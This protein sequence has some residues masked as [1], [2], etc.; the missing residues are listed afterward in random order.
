MKTRMV[1]LLTTTV[2]VGALACFGWDLALAKGGSGGGGS[3]GGGGGAAEKAAL[4]TSPALAAV[5]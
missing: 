1:K 3:H 5:T 2:A 4:R